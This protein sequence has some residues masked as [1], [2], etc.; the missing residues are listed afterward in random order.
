[1]KKALALIIVL[2][3]VLCSA[4]KKEEA[5]IEFPKAEE[6]QEEVKTEVSGGLKT[7]PVTDS[8]VSADEPAKLYPGNDAKSYYKQFVTEAPEQVFMAYAQDGEENEQYKGQPYS[9]EGTVVKI[10]E[11]YQEVNNAYG[12]DETGSDLSALKSNAF[13]LRTEMSDVLIM[14]LLPDMVE[15]TKE[16]YKDDL[17]TLKAYKV[18]YDKLKPYEDFP[19]EGEKVCVYGY[20]IGFDI[21]SEMPLFTYG[22][23]KLNHDSVF[24]ADYTEFRTDEMVSRKY[25]NY[26]DFELPASWSDV[27]ETGDTNAYYFDGGNLYWDFYEA[28]EYDLKSFIQLFFEDWNVDPNLNIISQDFV[29]VAGGATEGFLL[30]YTYIENESMMSYGEYLLFE[31][32]GRFI[33]LSYRDYN[34]EGTEASREDFLKIIDSIKLR[35]A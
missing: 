23:C 32:K 31:H 15:Q 27:L 33:L 35:S 20:Y 18:I 4:C 2:T 30:K 8:E 12:Y 5:K 29:P 19:A 3:V 11:T 16:A 1:M 22:I 6:K 17:M 34:G 9:L 7:D 24:G 21:K 14:N 25:K 13:I 28:E 10:F 26:V